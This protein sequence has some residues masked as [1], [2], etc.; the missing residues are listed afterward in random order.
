M[1]EV[2]EDIKNGLPKLNIPSPMQMVLRDNIMIRNAFVEFLNLCM[3]NNLGVS[4]KRMV[5]YIEEIDAADKSALAQILEDENGI[6][7]K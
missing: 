6:P 4:R 2:Q 5:S 3:E 1:D 7:R